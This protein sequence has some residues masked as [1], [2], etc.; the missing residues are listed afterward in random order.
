M[1]KVYNTPSIK[2]TTYFTMDRTNIAY[3]MSSP[4]EMQYKGD[5]TRIDSGTFKLNDLNS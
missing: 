1:K 3:N 2:V 5:D 4:V